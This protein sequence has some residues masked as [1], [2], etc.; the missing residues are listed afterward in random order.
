MASKQLRERAQCNYL[1]LL[2]LNHVSYVLALIYLTFL[3][4]TETFIKKLIYLVRQHEEVDA[5]AWSYLC[6]CEHYLPVRSTNL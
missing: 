4:L 1:S 6:L 2:C 3:T 5:F